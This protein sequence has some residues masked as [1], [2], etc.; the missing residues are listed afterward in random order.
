MNIKNH[1]NKDFWILW[2]Q[3]VYFIRK[4]LSLFKRRSFLPWKCCYIFLHL[5]SPNLTGNNLNLVFLAIKCQLSNTLKHVCFENAEKLRICAWNKV[6]FKKKVSKFGWKYYLTKSS[7][8]WLKPPHFLNKVSSKNMVRFQ[9][10]RTIQW[11]SLSD[12]WASKLR[13]M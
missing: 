12:H 7:L 10:I 4:K 1:Y 3:C 11:M 5:S 2:N 6:C 8:I 9:L 13:E